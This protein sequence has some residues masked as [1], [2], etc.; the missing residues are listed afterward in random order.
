[1]EFHKTTPGPMKTG[2]GL[3]MTDSNQM[4]GRFKEEESESMAED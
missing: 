1:M 4:L 3:A 2:F